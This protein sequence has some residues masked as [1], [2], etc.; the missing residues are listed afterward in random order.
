MLPPFRGQLRQDEI[1]Y[2]T[3]F[4][5]KKDGTYIDIGAND[6]I[7]MS[8]T[9]FFED[10]GWRGICV[11]AS[12]EMF[13]KLQENRKN[14]INVFGAAYRHDGEVT[15]RVNH[16]YTNALSGVEECYHPQHKYRIQREISTHG[17]STEL[18]TVPS[19]SVTN[20]LEKHNM[21][22]I[23]FMSLDVEGGELAVLEGI[24]FSKVD[25]KVIVLE[26]NYGNEEAYDRILLPVGYKKYQRVQ[27]DLIYHKP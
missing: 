16:G 4:L 14:T 19:F 11:E 20:L 25:I 21:T 7:D 24:D 27:W 2:N 3:F 9:K 18:I 5:G 22:H 6:G 15:F 12:P 17:G 13:A 26:D 10:I 1:V 23:D 8:N